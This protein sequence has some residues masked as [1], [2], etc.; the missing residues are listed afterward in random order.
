MTRSSSRDCL[1]V[2]AS[3]KGA[4]VKICV[5]LV[6]GVLAFGCSGCGDAA[7]APGLWPLMPGTRLLASTEHASDVDTESDH[8]HYRELIVAGPTGMSS[9]R[10]IGLAIDFA[11]RHG[12]RIG[13]P[14]GSMLVQIDL[15]SKRDYA[16]IGTLTADDEQGFVASGYR[17]LARAAARAHDA[18]VPALDI[19]LG[20]L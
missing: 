14:L 17:E 13:Q 1:K 3:N 18:R 9:T 2:S 6:L 11:L 12:W 4:A 19:T 7:P 15:P 5:A 20:T 8:K 10:L 16:A